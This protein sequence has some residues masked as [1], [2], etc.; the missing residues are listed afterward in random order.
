[1]ETQIR[2]VLNDFGPITDPTVYLRNINSAATSVPD[3]PIAILL[4]S[5]LLGL[6]GLGKK[7]LSNKDFIEQEKANWLQYGN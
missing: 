7:N 4:G 5:G 6:F 3:A 1:M 2:F